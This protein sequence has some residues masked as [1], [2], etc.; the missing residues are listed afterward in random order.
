MSK[1][2]KDLL[3]RGIENLYSKYT[4]KKDGYN[5]VVDL[6]LGMW[7]GNGGIQPCHSGCEGVCESSS[8]DSLCGGFMGYIPI[9]VKGTQLYIV[10]CAYGVRCECHG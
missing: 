10:M 5:E 7:Y 4:N 6:V 8:G 1:K 2:C 3:E 9:D